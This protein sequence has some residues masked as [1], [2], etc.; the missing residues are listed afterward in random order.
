MKQFTIAELSEYDGKSGRPAYIG[1]MGKVYDVSMSL[2]WKNGNHMAQHN[3]GR[4]LS[5]EIAFAPHGAGIVGMFPV[6]GDLR[7]S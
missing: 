6:V 5:K 4:D 2:R 7:V 3:A 1:F